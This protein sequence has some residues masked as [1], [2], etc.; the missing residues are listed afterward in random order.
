[1]NPITWKR[2]QRISYVFFGLMFVHLLLFLMPSVLA[3]RTE[4]QVVVTV[5][6]VLGV[7]YAVLRV[8][9]FIHDRKEL[10]LGASFN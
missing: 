5:Y 7:G 8:V 6:L 1:M 9:R 10:A 4:T 3:G 2:V